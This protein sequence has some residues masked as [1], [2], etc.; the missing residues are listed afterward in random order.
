LSLCD[1]I[2]K[3]DDRI[4]FVAFLDRAM[5]SVLEMKQRPGIKSLTD[6]ETDLDFFGFIEPVFVKVCAD[7]ERYFGDLKSVR[8]NFAKCTIVFLRIPNAVVGISLEP[9]PTTPI[10][11]KIGRKYGVKLTQDT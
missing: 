5:K 3:L 2:L 7:L 11:D 4:R 1:E 8:L 9:G 6:K 10:V